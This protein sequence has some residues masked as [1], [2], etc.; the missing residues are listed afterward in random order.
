MVQVSVTSVEVISVMGYF[1]YCR[2]KRKC[3]AGKSGFYGWDPIV[4]Y[5]CICLYG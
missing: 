4:Y 2:W 3:H 1:S 5:I